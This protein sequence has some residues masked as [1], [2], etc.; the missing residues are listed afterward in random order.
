MAG[1]P[2]SAVR[3]SKAGATQDVYG[4]LRDL[5]VRGPLAPG[6]QLIERPLALRLGVSR[7]TL[8]TALQQLAYEGFVVSVTAGKYARYIV[9]PLTVADM[10]ELYTLIG[11]MNGVAAAGAA[12]SAAH[13]RDRLA[14]ELETLNVELSAAM[15]SGSAAFSAIYE[16]DR[17]FHARYV[18]AA[19]GPRLLS[20]YGIVVAQSERYGRMYV[21]ALVGQISKSVL[22]H[23]AIIAAIRAAD[24]EAAKRAA[25][26]NWQNAA[27]RF[28]RVIEAVGEH[29]TW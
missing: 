19:G 6:A 1:K 22:E 9:A 7:A 14:G 10:E 28:R 8:R 29:G 21:A 24:P 20:L 16:I 2:A 17:Q 15:E 4:Q 3:I 5:I 26:T 11:A 27:A 18:E 12:N 25:E 13:E 23:E